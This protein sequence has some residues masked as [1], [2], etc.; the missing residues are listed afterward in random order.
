MRADFG[1]SSAYPVTRKGAALSGVWPQAGLFS[2]AYRLAT[3]RASRLGVL[4]AVSAIF[5]FV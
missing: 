5:Y 2:I 4:A 1:S 3:L